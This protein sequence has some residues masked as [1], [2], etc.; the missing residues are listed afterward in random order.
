MPHKPKVIRAGRARLPVQNH[1]V[2][3]EW[4]LPAGRNHDDFPK[5]NQAQL[6]TK[7][8]KLAQVP[9]PQDRKPPT[10]VVPEVPD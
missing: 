7:H 10:Y 8:R 6:P 5:P 2:L 4:S 9:E 3:K 1:S